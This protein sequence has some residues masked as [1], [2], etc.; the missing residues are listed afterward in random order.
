MKIDVRPY[1]I[2][3]GF[4]IMWVF[5]QCTKCKEEKLLDE[6]KKHDSS[7]FGRYNHCRK[8]MSN[9]FKLHKE[10]N[11]E[12]YKN[13]YALDLAKKSQKEEVVKKNRYLKKYELRKT[14]EPV[15]EKIKCNSKK[16]YNRIYKRNRIAMDVDFRMRCNIRSLIKSVIKKQGYKKKSHTFDI[17]GCEYETFKAYFESLFKPGMTWE[18]HGYWHIDHIYPVSKAK[19]EQHL[20]QLNHYTNLQPLWADENLRKRNKITTLASWD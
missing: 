19:D 9:Y 3:L 8:C 14:L 1:W 7:T 15:V 18:N 16:E 12:S 5:K 13:R 2:L 17:L 6:F 10:K 11:K 20:L 4:F